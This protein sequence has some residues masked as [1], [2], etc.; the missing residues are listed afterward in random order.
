VVQWGGRGEAA[1]VGGW[2]GGGE[3]GVVVGAKAVNDVWNVV[4]AGGW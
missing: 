4:A 3:G 1:F 2:M